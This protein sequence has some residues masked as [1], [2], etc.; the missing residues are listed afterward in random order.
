MFIKNKIILKNYNFKRNINLFFSEKK[1]LLYLKGLYGHVVI[2]M[3][4]YY[5]LKNDKKKLDILYN[6][7]LIFTNLIK[8][9]N[10][11]YNK[12]MYIY[13]IRLKLRGLGFKIRRVSKNLYYFFF[14]YINM[15]YFYIPENI[16]IK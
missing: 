8:N 12:I 13:S 5:Y 4:N 15:F 6:N 7:K 2:K 3:P 11:F 9:I 1:S 14:N 10:V 16:L